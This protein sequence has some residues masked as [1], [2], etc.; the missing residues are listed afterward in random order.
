[1]SAVLLVLVLIAIQEGL[2]VRQSTRAI[3]DNFRQA[4]QYFDERADL[5]APARVRKE[6]SD[7]KIVLAELN[8]AT[9]A[10]V[11]Q[12][13]AMLP[14]MRTLVTAGH[15]DVDIAHQLHGVSS[16][17]QGAAGS[18]HAISADADAAVVKVND[19]LL[20]A[21][22]LADQLNAELE[23]TTVKLAPLPAQGNVIPAPTGGK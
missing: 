12:L 5:A 9:A 8:A 18:L 11:D 1:M 22:Q 2:A 14:D 16:S 6:L 21:L 15:N 19:R 10:D 23:R 17:L 3:V 4:N 20:A 13:A 7:L